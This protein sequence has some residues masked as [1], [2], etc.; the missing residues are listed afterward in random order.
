MRVIN[1]SL[2]AAALLLLAACARSGS[3]PSSTGKSAPSSTTSQS[4]APTDAKKGSEV[5]PPLSNASAGEPN[6]SPAEVNRKIIRNAECTIEMDNPEEGLRKIASIAEA[7]GGFVVTSEVRQQET[8]GGSNNSKTVTLIARVPS[9]QFERAVE[10]IESVGTRVLQSKRT[11]QDVTEEYIDLE[12]RILTK[13]ALET[14]FLEIMKQ[15][16]TVSDALE[17]QRQLAEVRTEIERLEGR[18]RFLENQSSLSTITA[19][20]QPPVSMVSAT[21]G[22]FFSSVKE[23]ISDGI[24]IA[25][26]IVLVFIRVVLALLPILLL[27]VLPIVLMWRF[28]LRRSRRR[29]E[30]RGAT[31]HED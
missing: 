14:Q 4:A 11:G 23:A 26:V 28:F 2:L 15:A 29:S 10:E 8:V 18:R 27:I 1:T 16:R 25:V 9:A 6:S 24:S 5:V 7:R 12:A 19:T 13:R 30:A 22:G 17:V 21:P 3:N 31:G 20:L